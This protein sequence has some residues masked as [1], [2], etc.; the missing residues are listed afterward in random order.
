VFIVQC[1][2]P[3]LAVGRRPTATCVLAGH[4][5]LHRRQ[6]R[7]NVQGEET[8]HRLQP[9]RVCSVWWIRS[10]HGRSRIDAEPQIVRH[11]D[12]WKVTLLTREPSNRK[13]LRHSSKICSGSAP[14]LKASVANSGCALTGRT[15]DNLSDQQRFYGDY[16]RRRCER[17]RRRAPGQSSI[18]VMVPSSRESAAI[19]RRSRHRYDQPRAT[20][21]FRWV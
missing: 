2:L 16:Q 13:R 20:R 17:L 4:C 12:G 5:S 19:S 10:D 11:D 21:Y 8:A 14:K 7:R 1:T 3:G 9:A 18:L 15:D 6:P